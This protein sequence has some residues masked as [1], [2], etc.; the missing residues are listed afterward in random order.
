M[1]QGIDSRKKPQ[2]GIRTMYS[3]PIVRVTR[4]QSGTRLK[5]FPE[6][7]KKGPTNTSDYHP[8]RPRKEGA[9]SCHTKVSTPSTARLGESL[10]PTASPSTSL[11]PHS[12]DLEREHRGEAPL[13]IL[14]P[15]LPTPTSL[16]DNPGDSKRQY[17]H[18]RLHG[19]GFLDGPLVPEQ[20]RL[21]GLGFRD[22]PNHPPPSTG[23]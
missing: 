22:D 9:S 21:H 19:P 4:I 16:M 15:A 3:A 11:T 7:K 1:E 20:Y 2:S 17:A 23:K 13:H 5:R 6:G 12:E 8:I 14:P 18:F 10:A